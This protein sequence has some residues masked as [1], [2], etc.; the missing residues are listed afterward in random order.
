ML[1]GIGCCSVSS[2]VERVKALHLDAVAALKWDRTHMSTAAT[3]KRSG[4]ATKDFHR[5]EGRGGSLRNM[6]S[7]WRG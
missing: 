1:G 6:W 2:D 4:A 5:T 3:L 7:S